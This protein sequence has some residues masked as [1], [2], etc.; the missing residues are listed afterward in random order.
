MT[1]Y[2]TWLLIFIC[3]PTAVQWAFFYKHLWKYRVVFMFIMFASMVFGVTWDYY[4]IWQKIWWWPAKCCSLPRI[5][6]LPLE[7]LLFM[8]FTSL[9]LST[10]T[11]VV[12][13]I[14]KTHRHLKKK[15]T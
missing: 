6:G 13:D 2:I 7:E 5:H 8:C 11:I 14:I 1:P 12:R 4:A 10:L 9:Y 3:L 15:R